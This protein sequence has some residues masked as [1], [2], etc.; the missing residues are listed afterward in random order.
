MSETVY[1]GQIGGTGNVELLTITPQPTPGSA[2]VVTLSDVPADLDLV[3]YGARDRA[4]RA[5]PGA[6][7]VTLQEPLQAS[8]L[9]A[10]DA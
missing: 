1:T 4:R 10:A 8:K 3:L 6:L 7:R 2:I 9:L 5:R